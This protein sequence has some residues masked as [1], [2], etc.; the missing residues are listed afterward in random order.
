MKARGVP[1][2]AVKLAEAR[3]RQINA[4]CEEIQKAPV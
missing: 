2:E 3:L 1:E 4:A